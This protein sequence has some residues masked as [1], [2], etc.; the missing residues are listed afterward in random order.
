M[1]KLLATLFAIV[2]SG[3]IQATPQVADTL[4]VGT[5]TFGTYGFTLGEQLKKTIEEIF[6][7]EINNHSLYFYGNRKSTTNN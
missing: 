1:K 6:D 7:I 4:V 3:R 5:N 2:F